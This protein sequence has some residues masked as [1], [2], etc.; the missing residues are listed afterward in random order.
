MVQAPLI[1]D[2]SILIVLTTVKRLDLLSVHFPLKIS[3]TVL[4]EHAGIANQESC[5][6]LDRLIG[7][8]IVEVVRTNCRFEAIDLSRRDRR[9][10]FADAEGIV[11]AKKDQGILLTEDER[12]QDTADRENV[13]WNNLVG[14]LEMAKNDGIVS[15]PE[16]KK[17]VYAIELDANHHLA[18]RDK[19]MLGV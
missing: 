2:T 16:M 3:K 15:G 1:L 7:D 9:L 4:K 12:M 19:T 5:R 11:W 13:M 10:S 14:I 8:K 17:L 6:Y 18:E